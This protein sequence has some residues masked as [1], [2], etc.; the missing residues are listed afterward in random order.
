MGAVAERP[1]YQPV[2]THFRERASTRTHFLRLPRRDWANITQGIKREFRG[3]GSLHL[4]VLDPPTP[5]IAYSQPST[6]GGS[7]FRHE[8]IVCEA[9]WREPLGAISPESLEAEGFSS[10]AEFRQYWRDRHQQGR[11]DPLKPVIAFR[12][13]PWRGDEDVALFGRLLIERLYLN[14]ADSENIW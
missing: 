8:L 14:V 5:V 1:R 4:E 9:A 10:L 7:E 11:F 13:R 12:V 2:P 3:G 6:F